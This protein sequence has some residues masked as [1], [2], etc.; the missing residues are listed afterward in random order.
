MKR[1]VHFLFTRKHYENKCVLSFSPE[2]SK[3]EPGKHK[4]SGKAKKSATPGQVEHG[5]EEIFQVSEKNELREGEIL[6]FI[7][8][9]KRM[10]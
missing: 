2:S 9:L 7:R 4:G 8:Y 1:N 10:S 3:D 5:R 6:D